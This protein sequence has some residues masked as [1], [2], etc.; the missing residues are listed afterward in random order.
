M[1][2]L[3]G[4]LLTWA[5]PI[6][7]CIPANQFNLWGF[8]LANILYKTS[9]KLILFFFARD[10]YICVS[11]HINGMKM[12]KMKMFIFKHTGLFLRKK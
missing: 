1:H 5:H 9:Q 2:Q 7:Q 4:E 3:P 8:L 6:K 11:M 10:G 12:K